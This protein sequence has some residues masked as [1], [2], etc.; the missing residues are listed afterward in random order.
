MVENINY[1]T[2][3][4]LNPEIFTVNGIKGAAGQGVGLYSGAFRIYSDRDSGEG[5]TLKITIAESYEITKIKINYASSGASTT[6]DLDLGGTVQNISALKDESQDYNDLAISYFSIKNTH[7]GGST[8]LQIHLGSIEIT[9]KDKDGPSEPTDQEKVILD[10]ADLSLPEQVIEA[11]TFNLP[12]EGSRGSTI[13]WTV[14]SG[15]SPLID[16]LTGVYT[17]PDVTEELVLQATASLGIE[18]TSKTF[19]IEL[20]VIPLGTITFTEDFSFITSASNA[21]ATSI[22]HIDTNGFSWDLLG[23]PGD[24]DGFALGS[25]ADGN[26]IKV[27]AQSG[28]SSFSVDIKRFYT[29]L[30][31]RSVELFINGISYGTFVVDKSS[32]I[33]QTWLVENINVAGDVTIEL[34]STSPGTRGATDVVSFG[35]TTYSGLNGSTELVSIKSVRETFNGL[36]VKTKGVITSSVLNGNTYYAFMQDDFSGIYI[37]STTELIVGNEITIKGI[38]QTINGAV[39]LVDINEVVVEATKTFNITIINLN[40]LNSYL[41]EFIQ[42]QKNDNT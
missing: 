28:I 2:H 37:E 31:T 15:D 27:V 3:S 38:K 18:S 36:E 26:Y 33:A 19:I 1:A 17:M 42:G 4:D 23:R 9:F 13:T 39:T 7:Q 34:K 16:L 20:Y 25:V 6:A 8:N 29:N 32:D 21:Y 41:G 5:N 40:E 35:W 14:A 24:A 22:Q 30:N 12:T 11:G 10:L